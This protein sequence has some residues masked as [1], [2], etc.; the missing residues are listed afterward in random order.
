MR[1][2]IDGLTEWLVSFGADKYIHT[3]AMQIIAW[4]IAYIFLSLGFDKIL[5][6]A[7]AAVIS[8]TIGILKECYDKKTQGLFDKIDVVFDSIGVIL[9]FIMFML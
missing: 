9:F 4:P 7:C 2:K 1:R 3:L 5:S 8:I 6:G